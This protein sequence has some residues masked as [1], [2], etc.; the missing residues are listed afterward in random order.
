MRPEK[1]VLRGLSHAIT[2][3]VLLAVPV[4][5]LLFTDIFGPETN[6]LAAAPA[7]SAAESESTESTVLSNWEFTGRGG[8]GW[9]GW[10]SKQSKPPKK[11]DT[12]PTKATRPVSPSTHQT[13]QPKPRPCCRCS[14]WCW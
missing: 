10:G 2:V 9:G 8:W 1:N 7:I 3:I 11:T 5:A 6:L 14:C 12:K 4:G 13:K